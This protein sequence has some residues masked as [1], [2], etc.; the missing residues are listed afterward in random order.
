MLSIS[1]V[2]EKKTIAVFLEDNSSEHRILMRES[3]KK[4]KINA[5][6]YSFNNEEK[7]M[8]VLGQSTTFPDIIFL[9]F[10]LEYEPAVTCLKR[11]RV[12]KKLS[13]VPVVVF[14]PC[15][16]LKDIDEA[17]NN[18][19][20]LFIPKPVFMKES[21]RTL[22]KIFHPKWRQT[23]IKPN[24]NKFVLTSNAED[25]DKLSLSSY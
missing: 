9:T 11:I 3:F 13:N 24:R 25:T 10:N 15:M 4:A 2:E 18:G 21:T 23:L 16:Y 8:N 5:K 12:R 19:A 6:V 7:L 17:F 1:G 22:Q 20:G 14:S